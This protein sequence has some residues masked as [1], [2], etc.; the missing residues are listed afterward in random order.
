MADISPETPNLKAIKA[1]FGKTNNDNGR[2]LISELVLM[3]KAPGQ[4]TSQGIPFHYIIA[5]IIEKLLEENSILAF[6]ENAT[7]P[8]LAWA[9]RNL[10][11]L[12]VMAKYVCSSKSR[13]ERF[14]NDVLITWVTTLERLLELQEALAREVGG[15]QGPAADVYRGL[16]RLQ[17]ERE[18]AGL[19]KEGPLIASQCAKAVKL[20]GEYDAIGSVT[21]SLIH[22]SA[23]SVLKVSDLALLEPLLVPKGLLLA[24]KII[25]EIRD[26]IQTHGYQPAK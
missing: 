7:I 10:M 3:A 16:A 18:A 23:H 22:P 15:G 13:L 6:K 25:L 9:V 1:R 26:H 11:E 17:K 8:E 21:S 12:R 19:G 24:S 14:Q 4:A 2:K 20:K 5:R